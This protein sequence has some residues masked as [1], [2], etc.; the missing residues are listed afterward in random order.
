MERSDH[1]GACRGDTAKARA[2]LDQLK[3]LMAADDK[4]KRKDDGRLDGTTIL[5]DE[6]LQ[7][8]RLI[9]E[10]RR[11]DAEKLLAPNPNAQQ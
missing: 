5:N 11:R 4:M 1:I 2:A 6:F 7:H 9:P 10:V 8:D 3:S